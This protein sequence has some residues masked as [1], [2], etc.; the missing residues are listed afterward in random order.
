M[1]ITLL[2]YIKA[3]GHTVKSIAEKA[4]IT[5]RSLENYTTNR[6]PLKNARAWF[7]VK[8]AKALETTP[9]YLITLDTGDD[10]NE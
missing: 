6:Y 5:S 9:E 7:I 8:L 2:D 3:Q 10:K 4:E 1:G